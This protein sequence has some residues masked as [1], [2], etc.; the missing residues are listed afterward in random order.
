MEIKKMKSFRR[1]LLNK[2]SRTCRVPVFL[3]SVRDSGADIVDILIENRRKLKF[4]HNPVKIEKHRNSASFARTF[5]QVPHAYVFTLDD[6]APSF[7]PLAITQLNPITYETL[8]QQ[9][10]DSEADDGGNESAGQEILSY[11]SGDPRVS[12]TDFLVEFHWISSKRF[13]TVKDS[14]PWADNKREEE[15]VDLNLEQFLKSHLRSGKIIFWGRLEE[16]EL[17][18]KKNQLDFKNP[19]DFIVD[20]Q[21][22]LRSNILNWAYQLYQMRAQP[23]PS[24]SWSERLIHSMDYGI[25]LIDSNHYI[26]FANKARRRRQK[27]NILGKQCVQVLGCEEHTGPCENCPIFDSPP[28]NVD[29]SRPQVSSGVI[30]DYMRNPKEKYHIRE[31]RTPYFDNKFSLNQ[32]YNYLLTVSVVRRQVKHVIDAARRNINSLESF[33]SIKSELIRVFQEL[34]FSRVRYYEAAT[35]VTDETFDEKLGYNVLL[36]A[37]VSNP[38]EQK[39]F[40]ELKIPLSEVGDLDLS[41]PKI[42]T[43]H[44]FPG[45][46]KP[47]WIKHLQLTSIRWVDFPLISQGK[48]LGVIGIDN[49]DRLPD[50]DDDLLNELR[51][52]VDYLNPAITN[53]K[54]KD[55]LAKLNEVGSVINQQRGTRDLSFNLCKYLAELFKCRKVAIFRYDPIAKEIVKAGIFLNFG[56]R[57]ESKEHVIYRGLHSED[58]KL[59]EHITGWFMKKVVEL[60]SQSKALDYTLNIMNIASRLFVYDREY[61]ISGEHLHHNPGH[62]GKECEII[63]KYIDNGEERKTAK[64]N[65]LLFAPLIAEGEPIGLIRLSNNE[66]SGTIAFSRFQQEILSGVVKQVSVIVKKAWDAEK[67][68]EAILKISSELRGETDLRTICDDVVKKVR[69]IS[70]STTAIILLRD[71]KEPDCLRG[72]SC[73]TAGDTQPDQIQYNIPREFDPNDTKN[74]KGVGLPI[75]AF[76][77]GERLRFQTREEIERHL[78]FLRAFQDIFGSAESTIISPL[79]VANRPVG[80]LRIQSIRAN[81]YS[82]DFYRLFTIM[83]NFVELA[84]AAAYELQERDRNLVIFGH[85]MSSAVTQVRGL[86][87]LMERRYSR[88]EELWKDSMDSTFKELDKVNDQCKAGYAALGHTE[89]LVI[90]N[91][92]RFLTDLGRLRRI[93]AM[94]AFNI[95][96]YFYHEDVDRESFRPSDSIKK[97]IDLWTP[98]A[99]EKF[100]HIDFDADREF[101]RYRITQDRSKFE[102]LIYNLISNA[103]KYCDEN[104]NISMLAETDRQSFVCTISNYGCGI[105]GDD[106]EKIFDDGFRSKNAK[107]TAIGLGKGLF[108]IRNMLAGQL[109]GTIELTRRED[110]TT[111]TV[112]IADMRR[113]DFL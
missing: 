29:R 26:L 16:K 61:D 36:G 95:Q 27:N 100:C 65:S 112:I 84:I 9:S 88:I 45:P 1:F 51:L 47:S 56:K 79:K 54:A 21:A 58:Y 35:D 25:T 18:A 113:R 49:E 33:D 44:D 86:A 28:A 46:N 15:P 81:A 67:N 6:Y 48:L 104:T 90:D 42:Y 101:S 77:T 94:M 24:P 55:L 82:D 110:P 80:I 17:H 71:D 4:F 59:G 74:L 93:G 70:H 72:V 102:L 22:A 37:Q 106:V 66:R 99:Q 78:A 52:F 41:N 7:S 103:V 75:F 50:F 107:N 5:H 105:P 30:T 11:F 14:E 19:L 38:E 8:E 73:A 64:T 13:G 34:G 2:K 53:I 3:C 63:G 92:R 91:K 87:D 57:F 43:I 98:Y 32:Y 89:P 62:I 108:I 85:E 39:N 68:E 60:H 111:F 96:N 23:E 12:D 97:L 20:L 109:A 83:V 10:A 76:L 40:L 31:V 69:D